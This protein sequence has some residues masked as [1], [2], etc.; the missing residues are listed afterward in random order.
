LVVLV[1]FLAAAGIAWAL[2]AP[3]WVIAVLLAP[4]AWALVGFLIMRFL[5]NFN[6]L[7]KM[8]TPDYLPDGAGEVLDLG[9]GLGRATIMVALARPKAHITALDNFSASYIKD[10]GEAPLGQNL[11]RA[12]VHDRVTIRKGDI[13]HLPLEN[14]TFDALVS[15]FAIDHTSDV[16]LAL[17]EAKR[18]LRPGGQ[19]L[20]LVGVR[21]VRMAVAFAPLY[22][23]NWH[24][25]RSRADWRRELEAAGFAIAAEGPARSAA[26]FLLNRPGAASASQSGRAGR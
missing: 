3:I 1:P 17:R 5:A 26:W 14:E 6:E 16:A 4:A 19:F 10:H 20:L 9:C 24:R 8:P 12:G 7:P 15:S 21:S 11:Q 25:I 23:L 2:G 18:V 22:A 13:L